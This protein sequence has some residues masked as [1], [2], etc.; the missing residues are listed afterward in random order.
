MGTIYFVQVWNR[1]GIPR[2]CGYCFVMDIIIQKEQ[3]RKKKKVFQS[4]NVRFKAGKTEN[5]HN[6]TPSPKS[7]HQTKTS[8][9]QV[10]IPRTM[11]VG[12]SWQD[13]MVQW[14]KID[15]A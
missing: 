3:L 10:Q 11:V 8:P 12:P 15:L 4:K 6:P 5:N 9:S 1:K 13:K 2:G 7:R 14:K